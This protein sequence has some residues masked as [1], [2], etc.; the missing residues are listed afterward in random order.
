[1]LT[2]TALVT[3]E[4]QDSDTLEANHQFDL[5]ILSV[6]PKPS[7]LEFNLIQASGTG[8]IRF[9][10]CL[11]HEHLDYEEDSMKN[12]TISAENE[13]PYYSCKVQKRNISGVSDVVKIEGEPGMGQVSPL[14]TRHVMVMVED[15]NEPPIFT[16]SVKD[17]VVMEN[18]A[19][20]HYL[21]TFTARDLDTTSA[22][23]FVYM[24]GEDPGDWVSV[25]SKIGK[26]TTAK[27]LDGESPFVKD[28]AYKV[29]IH[30]AD[31]VVPPMTGTATLNIHLKDENDNTP[32]LDVN[33]MD[34]C[35]SAGPSLANI[36][37]FDLDEDPYSGPFNFKLHEDAK[38]K[39]RVDPNQGKDF[40]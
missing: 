37:A 14:F 11:D 4:A 28:N 20:G 12:L 36:T 1:M 39:W 2:G 24:K 5:R 10:G 16:H 3:V 35:Q 8:T 38:G 23:N 34:M 19:V 15:V 7:D 9:K 21:E 26:V 33:I 29:T 31:S 17:V 25:D 6:T 27:I 40:F 13:I 30:A 18:V 22:N 32:S